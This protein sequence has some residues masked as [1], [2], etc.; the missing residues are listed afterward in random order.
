[1]SR[2]LRGGFQVVV[3]YVGRMLI[4]SGELT[5]HIRGRSG[6]SRDKQSCVGGRGMT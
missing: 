5:S 3:D 4:G 2:I 1:M 6:R